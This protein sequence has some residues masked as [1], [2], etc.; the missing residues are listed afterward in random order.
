MYM[1][2]YYRF[3]VYGFYSRYPVP[4][5]LECLGL[6]GQGLEMKLMSVIHGCV[7]AVYPRYYTYRATGNILGQYMATHGHAMQFLSKFLLYIDT[8]MLAKQLKSTHPVR[9]RKLL[10]ILLGLSGTGSTSFC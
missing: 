7:F 9:E 10:L 4:I 2:M 8:C 3:R 1:Y 6:Y 5:Y